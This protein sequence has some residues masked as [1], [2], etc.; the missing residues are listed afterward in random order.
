MPGY[1]YELWWAI[2]APAGIAAE[3]RNFIGSAITHMLGTAD[4]KKFL[5]DQSCEPW[6][7]PPAQ[8]NELLPKEIER[9]KKAAKAAGI[10]SQ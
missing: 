4:M 6:T 10:A 5:S 2:F 9:Y 8:L 3:R 7:L 1:S